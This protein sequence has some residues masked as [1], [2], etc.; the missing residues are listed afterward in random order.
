MAT[1][2]NADD[3]R[4]DGILINHSHIRSDEN[5]RSVSLDF[6]S[7]TKRFANKVV[8]NNISLGVPNGEFVVVVGPSGCGKTTLLN[9]AGGFEALSDGTIRIGDNLV[10]TKNFSVP[11]NRR[12]IGVVFQSLALWPHMNVFENVKFPLSYRTTKAL[13][14]KSGEKNRVFE[15]LELVGLRD[16]AVVMPHELSGGQ[17]QRVALARALVSSPEILLMDEP[18]SSLDASLKERMTNDIRM[19]HE[20]VY[21]TVLYVTHDQREAMTLA[22]K[23]VVMNDGSLQQMDT[24]EA[25]Y[26]YPATPFVAEFFSRATVIYGSNVAVFLEEM[27][28]REE[29]NLQAVGMLREGVRIRQ[30]DL[31]AFD[32][33]G[34]KTK[35]TFAK[36]LSRQ[37]LGSTYEY[38]VALPSGIKVKS[39]ADERFDVNDNVS[40]SIERLLKF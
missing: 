21:N 27:G 32:A 34:H 31:S 9:L 37:F 3:E 1:K 28:I 4:G 5:K 30:P 18:L 40:I 19:I 10:S 14:Q 2:K 33:D 15:M 39:V 29:S 8:V 25:V 7:V 13:R 35:R 22:T 24:P 11:A 26:Q 6:R 23:V 36:V 16:K 38:V 12:N 17:R 20:Q